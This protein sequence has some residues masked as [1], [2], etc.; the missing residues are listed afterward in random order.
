M[1]TIRFHVSHLVDETTAL[2]Y[3]AFSRRDPNEYT[4]FIQA[5]L[6]IRD[7]ECRP[8][9]PNDPNS[10]YLVYLRGFPTGHLKITQKVQT[11]IARQAGI[12]VAEFQIHLNSEIVQGPETL[13]RT[14]KDGKWWKPEK[15]INRYYD[16]TLKQRFQKEF[17]AQCPKNDRCI[18]SSHLI[19][20]R[21]RKPYNF[22]PIPLPISKEDTKK[23]HDYIPPRALQT[24]I[25][26]EEQRVRGAKSRIPGRKRKIELDIRDSSGKQQEWYQQQLSKLFRYE[27]RINEWLQF[28]E[29]Y[30]LSPSYV[31]LRYLIETAP[32]HEDDKNRPSYKWIL[33]KLTSGV[34]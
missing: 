3:E 29:S 19:L 16:K 33:D 24:I 27:V 7:Y 25:Q 31:D 5:R 14:T 32:R 13:P 1:D 17:T 2:D 21:K 34:D 23:F 6:G 18:R 4:A 22:D 11:A 10:C 26:Y 12:T 30:K 8:H 15:T 20:F 9:Y 28:Y